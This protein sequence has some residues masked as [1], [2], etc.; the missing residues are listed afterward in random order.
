[1]EGELEGI[2]GVG[3]NKGRGVRGIRE[4]KVK[5]NKLLGKDKQIW[6]VKS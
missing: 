5:N 3:G 4:G 2:K 6:Q 1:M